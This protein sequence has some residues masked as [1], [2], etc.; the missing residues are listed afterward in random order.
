MFKDAFKFDTDGIIRI[1]NDTSGG[2][3]L[4][5]S[6]MI[7][8]FSTGFNNMTFYSGII[9]DLIYLGISIYVCY[10]LLRPVRTYRQ[11]FV[12]P[13][14]LLI[15][16][17]FI[18]ILGVAWSAYSDKDVYSKVNAEDLYNLIKK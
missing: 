8:G 5:N 4:G 6:G 17:L 14:S 13:T 9:M 3:D 1:N 2:A 16:S 10:S 7:I 11:S 18:L 12:V 15:F